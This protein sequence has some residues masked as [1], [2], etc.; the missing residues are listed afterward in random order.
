MVYQ[1]LNLC[2]LAWSAVG[3]P[4]LWFLVGCVVYVFDVYDSVSCGLVICRV[5]ALNFQIVISLMVHKIM[6]N[7]ERTI[8]FWA[9]INSSSTFRFLQDVISV[10]VK[11]HKLFPELYTL[12]ELTSEKVCF[13]N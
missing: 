2:G 10:L 4:P 7:F 6:M 13:Q 8:S 12:E 9:S 5:G 3:K 1:Q 11:N